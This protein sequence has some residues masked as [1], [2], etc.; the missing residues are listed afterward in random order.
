LPSE[1]GAQD[2]VSYPVEAERFSGF[3]RRTLRRLVRN[4]QLRATKIGGAMMIHM[5]SLEAYVETHPT[6]PMLPG[7]E[8]A[9]EYPESLKKHMHDYDHAE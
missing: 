3:N 1:N 6:Q 4:G 5:H 8:E 9:D 2:W 7:F